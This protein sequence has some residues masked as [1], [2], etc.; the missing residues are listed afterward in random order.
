MMNIHRYDACDTT[1]INIPSWQPDDIYYYNYYYCPQSTK[2]NKEI[3]LRFLEILIDK[4]II[5][6]NID[7]K[8]LLEIIKEAERCF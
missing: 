1:P 5:K 8:Q 6:K 2:N 4:K 7:I 3:L